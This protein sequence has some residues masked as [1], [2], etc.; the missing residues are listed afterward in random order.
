VSDLLKINTN[1]QILDTVLDRLSAKKLCATQV[2]SCA[3]G[4]ENGAREYQPGRISLRGDTVSPI[5][6]DNVGG[7]YFFTINQNISTDK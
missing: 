1:S 6:P 2:K 7:V 5:P 4:N 3:G